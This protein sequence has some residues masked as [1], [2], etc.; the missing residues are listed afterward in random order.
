MVLCCCRCAAAAAATAT[1]W[2]SRSLCPNDGFRMLSMEK[3]RADR[4]GFL[5]GG[6]KNGW[7]SSGGGTPREGGGGGVGSGE[8]RAEFV[9]GDSLSEIG[10]GGSSGAGETSVAGKMG[11]DGDG[12][13]SGEIADPANAERGDE[14]H[15]P[16]GDRIVAFPASVRGASI[17]GQ[18]PRSV[19]SLSSKN[20][21]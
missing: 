1:L 6:G 17:S 2:S 3:G 13:E 10:G 18:L 5:F 16:L 8:C 20:P 19:N 9:D 4:S 11:L 12:T 14:R 21:F 15:N 7:K